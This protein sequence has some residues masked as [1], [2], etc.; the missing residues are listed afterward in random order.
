M[1]NKTKLWRSHRIDAPNRF[2]SCQTTHQNQKGKERK[3]GKEESEMTTI[4]FYKKEQEQF[5]AIDSNE[6]D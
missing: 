1:G 3:E 2:G 5:L 4:T 6:V